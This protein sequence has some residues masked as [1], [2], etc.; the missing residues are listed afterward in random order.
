MRNKFGLPLR[1]NGHLCL[2]GGNGR[3]R[4]GDEDREKKKGYTPE[5]SRRVS[6][7]QQHCRSGPMSTE[8]A[9]A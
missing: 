7:D 9:V 2:A 6:D 5:V 8:V 3:K 4:G 1:S